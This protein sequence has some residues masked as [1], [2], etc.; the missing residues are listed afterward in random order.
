MWCKDIYI[1]L[2]V[3]PSFHPSQIPLEP[4]TTLVRRTTLRIPVLQGITSFALFCLNEKAISFSV[5][6]VFSPLHSAQ[7]PPPAS[8]VTLYHLTPCVLLINRLFSILELKQHKINIL[9]SPE[10]C[11]FPIIVKLLQGKFYIVPDWGCSWLL[12]YLSTMH[13]TMA[14]ISTIEKNERDILKRPFL[15]NKSISKYSC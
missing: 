14:L 13:K 11:L 2:I 9:I 15:L 12:E 6:P 5:R 1:I 8:S 4:F 7:S 3:H 10:P